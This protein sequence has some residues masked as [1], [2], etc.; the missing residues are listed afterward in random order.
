[1]TWT[2]FTEKMLAGQVVQVSK[3]E[4]AGLVKE[5]LD[6]QDRLRLL[7]KW[8]AMPYGDNVPIFAKALPDGTPLET[9]IMLEGLYKDVMGQREWSPTAGYWVQCHE[10]G[11]MYVLRTDLEEPTPFCAECERLASAYHEHRNPTKG[12]GH[13]AVA[14]VS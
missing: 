10:C 14:A 8:L 9:G 12:G 3:E 5:G 1:M 7:V 2:E 6:Y 4:M 13:V 11:S